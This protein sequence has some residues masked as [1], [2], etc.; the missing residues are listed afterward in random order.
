MQLM[1]EFY[2]RIPLMFQMM[3]FLF[4][5]W[6]RLF[7]SWCHNFCVLPIE[8]ILKKYNYNEP[9]ESQYV[10][11][12][13]MATVM[14]ENMLG[15]D[16]IYYVSN[17]Q[18][19][20]HYTKDFLEFVQNQHDFFMSHPLKK[21]PYNSTFSMEPE[22]FENLFIVRDEDKTI[23]KSYPL[24]KNVEPI[25]WENLPEFSDIEFVFVEYYHPRMFNTIEFPI[26]HN[27]YVIGNQ[28]LSQAYVLRRLELLNIYYIFDSEYEIRLMD[29]NVD[30]I[31][32]T[33]DQ[34]VEIR[35]DNYKIKK[36]IVNENSDNES[37]SS[38]ENVKMHLE[39]M[40][41]LEKESQKIHCYGDNYTSKPWWKIW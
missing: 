24:Y 16:D 31:I 10:Q 25:N 22:S 19:I 23:F 28:I 32:I 17:T 37:S 33:S 4:I 9:E 2:E 13:S 36:L 8:K 38:E 26:H 30:D 11:I 18:N 40:D 34:Y 3:V 20:F 15:F 5:H 29:H 41:A 7:L 1:K 6:Y 27:E 14:C 12:Y 39:D 21:H 35:K